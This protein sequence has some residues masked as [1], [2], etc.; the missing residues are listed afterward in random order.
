MFIIEWC[1][2]EYDDYSHTPVAVTQDRAVADAFVAKRNKQLKAAGWLR[3][4]CKDDREWA[5]LSAANKELRALFNDP[6]FDMDWDGA[7]FYV[8]ETEVQ[9][10]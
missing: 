2:G 9:L 6:L 3:G 10:L 7:S 5:V 8:R 4:Y 1:T